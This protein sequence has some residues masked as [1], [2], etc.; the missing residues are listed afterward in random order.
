MA[1]TDTRTDTRAIDD[2]S[3]KPRHHP[4]RV[5]EAQ[6]IPEAAELCAAM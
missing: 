4:L 2:G 5:G 6:R 1:P 3:R